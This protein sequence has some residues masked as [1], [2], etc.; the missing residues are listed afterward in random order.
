MDRSHE[1]GKQAF[2]TE[3]PF[4][5]LHDPAHPAPHGFD[6][7]KDTLTASRAIFGEVRRV[8]ELQVHLHFRIRPGLPNVVPGERLSAPRPEPATPEN[9]ADPPD[10]PLRS[11]SR[12]RPR[13]ARVSLTAAPAT[14]LRPVAT[15]QRAPPA[16]QQRQPERPSR[17][18]DP[19]G[20]FPIRDQ[21]AMPLRR[22]AESVVGQM[23][24]PHAVGARESRSERPPDQ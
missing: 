12:R 7:P 22:S 15:H 4:K 16:D 23:G 10:Q 5:V 11:L 14:G 21:G 18:Q 2:L 19:D 6:H 3:T 13:A 8:A 17:R 24:T 1:R 9:A 20:A